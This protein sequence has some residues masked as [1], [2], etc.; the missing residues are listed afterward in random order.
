MNPLNIAIV[1][2]VLTLFVSIGS[3]IITIKLEERKESVSKIFTLEN[4]ALFFSF[5]L[6]V[7]MIIITFITYKN[8]DKMF[9][10]SIVF[11]V[12]SL[13]MNV[14]IHFYWRIK[15]LEIKIK[16]ITSK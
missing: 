16:M 15:T 7:F 3:K 13:I 6:P 4:I 10:G 12:L 2:A 5:S 14:A 8:V 11:Q 9:I 1:S